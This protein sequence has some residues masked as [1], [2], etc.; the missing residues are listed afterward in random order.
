MEADLKINENKKNKMN[1]KIKRSEIKIEEM[2]K[3]LHKLKF[4]AIIINCYYQSVSSY[5]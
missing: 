3:L 4:S 5:L 2:N 1:V